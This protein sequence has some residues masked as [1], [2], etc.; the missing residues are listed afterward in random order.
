MPPLTPIPVQDYLAGL[1]RDPHPRLKLIADEGRAE[2]LPLV[3]PDTGALLHAIARA[4]G[5]QRILEIGTAI[6]Y[7]TLWLASALL[8]DGTMI[9]ME[10]EAARAA[11]ARDHL[12]AAGL[13]DRVS[14]MVGDATRFL[15]KVAGPFDVIFQDSD[16]QLYEP[17]L[18]RLVELLRPGGVLLTDNVLW[19]GEVVPGFVTEPKKKP[20]DTVAI[21]AYNQRLANDARLS[22]TFLQV[23]DGVSLSVKV[24]AKVIA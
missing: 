19:D 8:A 10:M 3:F 7:S 16:K 23:G 14:V 22:T 20:Q 12:A 13:G 21:A 1:R 24:G 11:R 4:S 9:S 18:D 6:G 2:G 17:M 15:H 5:A